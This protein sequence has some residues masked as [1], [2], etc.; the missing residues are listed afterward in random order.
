ME[1]RNS[2]KVDLLKSI[3]E[4]EESS[5]KPSVREEKRYIK[6]SDEVCVG[7]SYFLDGSGSLFGYQYNPFN[8][9]SNLEQAM[10]LLDGLCKVSNEHWKINYAP[11]GEKRIYCQPKIDLIYNEYGNDLRELIV[12]ACLWWIENN[13]HKT[14]I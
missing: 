10:I 6:Y 7:E 14:S 1:L 12:N 5:Y 3:L 2:R 13:E 9:E 4:H 11:T 8:P